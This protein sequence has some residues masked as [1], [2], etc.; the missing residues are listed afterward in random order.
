MMKWRPW[1]PLQSKKFEAKITVH[2]LSGLLISPHLHDSSRFSVE[3]K[4][5]GSKGI[6]LGSLRKSVRRN[7]T[8]EEFLREDGVVQWD[9]E[10]RCVCSFS[11]YKEGLFHPWEVS[12]T[13]FDVS[14]QL[15]L[16]FF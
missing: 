11:A 8:K 14:S 1:P 7:F 3:I 6:S 2:Q 13:V 16:H 15:G 9:E 5:K 10:F 4:W 12:F